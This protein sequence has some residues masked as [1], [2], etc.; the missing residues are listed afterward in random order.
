MTNEKQ[1]VSVKFDFSEISDAF[2]LIDGMSFDSYFAEDE[3]WQMLR[4]KLYD[5]YVRAAKNL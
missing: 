5:A 1:N 3:R 4:K 2:Q